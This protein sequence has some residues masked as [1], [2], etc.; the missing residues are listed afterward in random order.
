MGTHRT[1]YFNEEQNN[2]Q[3]CLSLDL[4]KEKRE[5]AS[6]K[7]SQCQQR[8]MRY[9]NKN[10]CVR[11]FQAGD[12]VLGKVN[13]NTRDPNHGALGPKWEGPYRV[14]RV[15]GPRAYKLA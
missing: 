11:Q 2:E 10:V 7:V 13:Q 3:I 1:E 5:G 4:L 12:W 9:Y 8:V 14:I 15:T 6:L